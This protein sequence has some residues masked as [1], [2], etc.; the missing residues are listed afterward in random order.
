MDIQGRSQI[1]WFR[2][3]VIDR[4]EFTPLPLAWLGVLDWFLRLCFF[5]REMDG[6]KER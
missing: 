4:F 6:S 3:T 5:V 2:N 1:T